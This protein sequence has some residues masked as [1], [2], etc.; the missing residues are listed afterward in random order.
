MA[1][2]QQRSLQELRHKLDAFI[3]GR[4]ELIRFLRK[5]VTKIDEHHR[6]V[7]IAKVVTDYSGISGAVVSLVGLGLAIPTGGLSLLLTI[8][9][10]LFAAASGAAHLGSD[11]VEHILNKSYINDLQKL[12]QVDERNSIE[13]IHRLEV[14]VAN[15]PNNPIQNNMSA[16]IIRNLLQEIASVT[17]LGLSI[18]RVTEIA[19]TAIRPIDVFTAPSAVLGER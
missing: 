16:E 11:V 9:G 1:D 2:K 7:K 5:A 12:S 6:N 18:V 3:S 19:S 17:S 4:E 14:Y 15:L 13:F 10:E 8:G